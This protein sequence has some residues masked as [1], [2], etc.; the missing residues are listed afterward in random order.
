MTEHLTSGQK[1]NLINALQLTV[2]NDAHEH[3]LRIQESNLVSSYYDKN[4]DYWLEIA[5]SN[6]N[7]GLVV[8][9]HTTTADTAGT[10]A[11]D[12]VTYLGDTNKCGGDTVPFF[13]RY[14]LS[15]CDVKNDPLETGK[16]FA[17]MDSAIDTIENLF[18]DADLVVSNHVQDNYDN[19]AMGSLETLISNITATE[20]DAF[21]TISETNISYVDTA[22]EV[23]S[24]GL[25]VDC[26]ISNM[27]G[28]FRHLFLQ[29][30]RICGD[31]SIR[32]SARGDS[33]DPADK[34]KPGDMLLLSQ[35]SSFKY[36]ID[37]ENVAA[38]DGAASAV[39]DPEQSEIDAHVFNAYSEWE[40]RTDSSDL[41]AI[42]PTATSASSGARELFNNGKV[43]L[44]V[45]A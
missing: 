3:V 7:N 38:S 40:N 43:F 14:V 39:N 15:K 10:G 21:T 42:H 29:I 33:S 44:K 26:Q 6:I 23:G 18:G 4:R 45:V 16:L 35:T 30:S 12:A 31:D 5:E 41:R 34:F 25:S 24:T 2:T 19:G 17:P 8:V 22:N 27:Q 9:S 32:G 13:L 1:D 37:V 28:S 20:T 36:D 11:E